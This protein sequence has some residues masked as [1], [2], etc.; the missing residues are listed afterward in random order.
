VTHDADVAARARRQVRMRD[1][2]IES[3]TALQGRP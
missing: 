2:L 3:E 1:G